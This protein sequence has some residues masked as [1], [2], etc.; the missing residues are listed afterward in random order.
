MNLIQFLAMKLH[1][2]PVFIHGMVNSIEAVVPSIL[3]FVNS[4]PKWVVVL[5]TIDAMR[6][7]ILQD[8]HATCRNIETILSIIGTSIHSILHEH[9]TVNKICSRWIP[10]MSIAQKMARVG[11]SKEMLKKY[12]RSDESLIYEIYKMSQIKQKVARALSTSKQIITCFFS[13]RLDIS[14][15]CQ[16]NNAQH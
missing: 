11:W 16:S 10:T 5:E 2:G 8:R 9:L 3:N 7:L 13:E 1:K 12:D 15:S 14:Q 6:Q 4:R